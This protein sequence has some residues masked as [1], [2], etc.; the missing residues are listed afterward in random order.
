MEEIASELRNWF[1][2]FFFIVLSISGLSGEADG[3]RVR[4]SNRIELNMQG[5]R[6]FRVQG[7]E[8]RVQSSGFRVQGLE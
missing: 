5:R 8:F 4:Q 3:I 7:S 2:M 1:A 6:K